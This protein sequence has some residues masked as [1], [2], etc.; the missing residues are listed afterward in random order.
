MTVEEIMSVS[1]DYR[2]DN[3]IKAFRFGHGRKSAVIVGAMRGNEY[4]Q[5]YICSL[6]G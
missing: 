3:Q 5:L 2:E 4:Q 6:L 1:T